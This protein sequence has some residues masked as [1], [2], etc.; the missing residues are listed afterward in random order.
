MS[1]DPFMNPDY[2]PDDNTRKAIEKLHHDG[3]SLSGIHLKY[4]D[5]TNSKLVNVNMS[6]ADL[7]RS[8]FSGSS[9]YGANLEGANLFKANLEGTNFSLNDQEF[10][11]ISKIADELDSND[12]PGIISD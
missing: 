9:M 7:T 4:A 10:K 5:M 2:K 3:I 8:D 6:V 11:K 1:K 12:Q